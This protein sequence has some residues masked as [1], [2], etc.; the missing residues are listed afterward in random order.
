MGRSQHKAG[1]GGAALPGALQRVEADV[2]FRSYI[3]IPGLSDFILFHFF[4]G[5]WDEWV[6]TARLLKYNEANLSLQKD[7]SRAQAAVTSAS[8]SASKT[9][10]TARGAQAGGGRRKE[11]GRGTKRGRDD[12]DGTRRPEMRLV[13]PD[14]LKVLLVDDWEAVTK[15]N[16][17]CPLLVPA[18]RHD[19]ERQPR[20]CPTLPVGHAPQESHCRR[21]TGRVQT[22]HS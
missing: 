19:A 21:D 15:N 3:P 6:P 11:G 14:T 4:V 5:S 18:A 8:A 1:D 22:A 9:S 17:V 20:M 12:D 10:N 2:R 7:L 16:Q 13:V